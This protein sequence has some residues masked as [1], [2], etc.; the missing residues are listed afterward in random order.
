MCQRKGALLWFV[1]REQLRLTT[2]TEHMSTYRFNR[3]V[4]S[5]HFCPN[6]G[7]HPFGEGTGPDGRAMAA[8]NLRCLEDFDLASVPVQYFDGRSA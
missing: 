2:P 7:I 1:P 8:I 3:H 6:C 5:H 4:I